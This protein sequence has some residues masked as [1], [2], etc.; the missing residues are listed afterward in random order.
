MRQALREQ[1]LKISSDT[2]ALDRWLQARPELLTL[3][4][5]AALPG[6]VDLSDLVSNHSDRRWVYPKV[7]G[8]SLTFH[9]ITH[10]VAELVSGAFGILEPDDRSP[11]VAIQEI[12]VF[13]CPGLAFDPN[14]GRLGRGRGFYDRLLACAGS[15]ALKAGVCSP[16]QLV[17]DT[18]PDSHDIAMDVVFAGPS[19]FERQT[20]SRSQL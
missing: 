9:A 8:E 11:E 15:D 4:V 13:L 1:D 12:D 3:S 5:Y 19:F 2:T 10:P 6:E 16:F 20:A 18:F 14:G 7:A 17:P